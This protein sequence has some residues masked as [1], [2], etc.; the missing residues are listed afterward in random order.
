MGKIACVADCKFVP[1]S[2]H[3]RMLVIFLLKSST[4]RNWHDCFHSAESRI[5]EQN[6]ELKTKN[7]AIETLDMIVKEKSQ[8]IAT[9]QNE[10]T[11]LEV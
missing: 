2:N 5:A 7:D 1:T 11:S 6:L 10:V 3:D 8:K 4:V 9:M